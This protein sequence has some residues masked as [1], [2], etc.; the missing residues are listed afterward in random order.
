[1]RLI[2]VCRNVRFVSRLGPATVRRRLNGLRSGVFF[3]LVPNHPAN[4]LIALALPTLA[5]EQ[6]VE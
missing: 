3:K 6:A 4:P 5:I 2:C 1:M